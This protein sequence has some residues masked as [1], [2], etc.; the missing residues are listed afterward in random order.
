VTGV[1]RRVTRSITTTMAMMMMM[2]TSMMSPLMT[3][4]LQS[5]KLDEA[6]GRTAAE[7][8]FK[9][10]ELLYRFKDQDK[11]NRGYISA[12]NFVRV[13]SSANLVTSQVSRALTDSTTCTTFLMKVGRY[14]PSALLAPVVSQRS[15]PPGA[16]AR[17]PGIHWDAHPS[18]SLRF[19]ISV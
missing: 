12:N 5:R 13:T 4:L 17:L 10:V 8:Q 2:M 19:S 1:R 9:R 7:I 18:I 3:S 15:A 14:I 11:Q 6:L 16:W